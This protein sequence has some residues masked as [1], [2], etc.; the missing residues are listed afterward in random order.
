MD[1]PSPVGAVVE[2]GMSAE[3]LVDDMFSTDSDLSFVSSVSP[4][5]VA[6]DE[7]SGVAVFELKAPRPTTRRIRALGLSGLGRKDPEVQ[8]IV[9]EVTKDRTQLVVFPRSDKPSQ[10]RRRV[11]Q[12]QD[13]LGRFKARVETEPTSINH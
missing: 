13:E 6:R 3:E 1:E 4:H 9:Q 8:V 2:V 12:L 5:S 11:Q 7:Q 10:Y